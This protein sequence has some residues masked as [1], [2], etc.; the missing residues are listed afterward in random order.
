[1]TVR[2]TDNNRM[3]AKNKGE[4]RLPQNFDKLVE[5]GDIAALKAVFNDCE[6]DA[7]S[8][9]YECTAL[10]FEG[11]PKEFARWLLERG[12]DANAL[13]EGGNTPL[14]QCANVEIAR[15]LLDFGAEINQP[16]RSGDTPLHSAV[17]RRRLDMIGLLI[18]RGSDIN[19]VNDMERTPLADALS[20][21]FIEEIPD[22]AEIAALLFGAGVEITPY[23]SANVKSI[24][25]CLEQYREDFPPGII[26]KAEA[27]MKK[28]YTLFGVKPIPKR[29]I[30]DG[31]SKI[32]IKAKKNW[33][34]QHDELWNFLVPNAGAARTVQGEVIRITGRISGEMFQNG[35]GNWDAD[36]RKMTDALLRHFASGVALS[37]ED[38]EKAAS[39]A[40]IIRPCGDG[41]DESL[42]LSELAVKWVLQ[43]PEPIPLSKIN[44]RR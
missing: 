36:Y 27:G 25:T 14:N 22:T 24:G 39:L 13:D 41:Y 26:K 23:M 16:N 11:I 20:G 19:A 34:K 10:H 43:N 2:N 15:L 6:P 12:A 1:M 32:I 28:L 4:S 30:H 3:K 29:K 17:A 40:T 42:G 33:Q 21:C 31:A 5:A 37:P 8:R 35:G 9:N 18:E 38:L 7:R 44:Y